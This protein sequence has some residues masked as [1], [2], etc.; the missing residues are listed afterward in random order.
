MKNLNNYYEQQNNLFINVLSSKTDTYKE[1]TKL[2]DTLTESKN[3]STENIKENICNN[4][5]TCL[6]Y[7][8]SPFSIFGSGIDFAYKICITN[9]HN[10]F[11]DYQKLSN[12]TNITEINSTIINTQSSEFTLIGLSIANMFFFVQ[13]RIYDCF[14]VDVS[15][16]NKSFDN[17]VSILNALSIFFSIFNFLFVIIFIFLTIS[18]YARPIKE[19]SY[20]INCSFN[21]I[22]SYSLTN[23]RNHPT[24]CT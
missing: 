5:E 3:N 18:N 15:N 4:N 17:N 7:L 19:S 11:L 6:K 24:T 10:L 16:L 8:D 9:I 20:R 23:F 14:A 1:I 2:F 21:F 22:K 12:N 13:E